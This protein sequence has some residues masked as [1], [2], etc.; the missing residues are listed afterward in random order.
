MRIKLT[1]IIVDDQDNALKFYA[2]VLGFRKKREIPVGE[3]KWLTVTSPE[4]PESLPPKQ[5]TS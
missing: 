3:Y 4:G 1:S 5:K 2:D